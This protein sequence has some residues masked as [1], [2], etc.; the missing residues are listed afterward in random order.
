MS[1]KQIGDFDNKG[2]GNLFS[3]IDSSL[4]VSAVL[5]NA[6][7]TSPT[8]VKIPELTTQPIFSPIEQKITYLDFS[9]G[10]L[11]SNK[12][13]SLIETATNIQKTTAVPKTETIPETKSN[14]TLPLMAGVGLLAY[15]SLK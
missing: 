5:R 9:S 14:K 11:Y 15:F 12:S 6:T 3:S 2:M 8:V 7:I 4:L 13:S 1:S 10:S